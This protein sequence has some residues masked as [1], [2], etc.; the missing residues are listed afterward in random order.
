MHTRTYYLSIGTTRKKHFFASAQSSTESPVERE[1]FAPMWHHG[2][3]LHHHPCYT[4][5]NNYLTCLFDCSTIF[6]ECHQLQRSTD[7]SQ[8]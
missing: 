7:V 4:Y 2:N 1:D 3:G 5:I 8:G 6:I